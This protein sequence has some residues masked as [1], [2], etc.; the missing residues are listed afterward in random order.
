MKTKVITKTTLLVL[1]AGLLI[2]V[3][4]LN[5]CSRHKKKTYHIGILSGFDFFFTTVDGFKAKMTELGYIEGKNMVYDVQKTKVDPV[6]YRRVL[7]KFIDEKADLIFVFPTEA[8]MEAKAA[9]QGKGIPVVFANAFTENTGL[10]NSVREPGGNITGVRW[11]G[12]D[13]A[14]KRFEIM[15]EFAPKAKRILIPYL[16]DYPIVKSQLEVLRPTSAAAGL[17]LIEIPARNATE[18]EAELQKQA[19]SINSKTDFILLIVEPLVLTPA[20]FIS[21]GKFAD[22]HKITIGGALMSV[23]GYESI[24]GFIPQ[25]IPQGKQA[26]YLADKI[27]KGAKAGTI[28]VVSAE[29]FL[30]INYKKAKKLGL[31]ISEGLLNSANEIIR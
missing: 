21:L 23:G 13:I 29:N 1:S 5:G 16:K 18:L 26:A 9:T 4:F 30:Q 15:R 31:N 28:P 10:V 22:E 17:S 25:N 24:F 3:M 6:E 14:L 20:P 8:A 2:T 7:S 27:L 12:S 19:K 11:A